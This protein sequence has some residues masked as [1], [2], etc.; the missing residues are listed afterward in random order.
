MIAEQSRLGCR[1]SARLSGRYLISYLPFGQIDF[2][3]LLR[4]IVAGTCLTL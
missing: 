4:L 1:G 3:G 2:P